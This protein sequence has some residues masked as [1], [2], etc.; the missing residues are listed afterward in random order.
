MGLTAIVQAGMYLT[1]AGNE[2]K[3]TLVAALLAVASGVLLLAG[4]LT[5][6]A[7]IGSGLTSIG[8]ALSWF[9]S[10]ASALSGGNRLSSALVITVTAAIVLLGPGAFSIDARLFGRRAIIIPEVPRPPKN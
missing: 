9:A 5:P 6:A 1:G 8:F 3:G 4:F 2:P 7:C 10:P